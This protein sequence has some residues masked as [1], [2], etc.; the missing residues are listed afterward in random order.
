MATRE[1]QTFCSSSFH[2]FAKRVALDVMGHPQVQKNRRANG[3]NEKYSNCRAK[4]QPAVS[5][6]TYA[7]TDYYRAFRLSKTRSAIYREFNNG[8]MVRFSPPEE[9]SDFSN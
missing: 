5:R 2:C 3:N 6:T 9:F 1:M 7:H 8:R 4:N